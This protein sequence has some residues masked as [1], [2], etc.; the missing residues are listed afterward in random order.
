MELT[1]L[2]RD[3]ILEWFGGRKRYIEFHDQQHDESELQKWLI[4]F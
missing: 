1:K 3:E 2:K 4:E